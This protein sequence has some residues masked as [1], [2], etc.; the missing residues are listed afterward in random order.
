MGASGIFATSP[1]ASWQR[2][3]LRQAK[4]FLQ[5]VVE[6]VPDRIFWKDRDLRYLGCNTRFAKDAGYSR[7]D[8]LTGKTDFEMGWKDQ[9]ELYRADDKAVLESGAPRLNIE[10]PQTTPDGDTIWLRTSKVPLRD[11]DDRIIGVLGL[12]QDITA[13]KKVT[14]ELRESERRFSRPAGK[15]GTDFHDA[16]PR[17]AD[18]L[19]Q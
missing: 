10:E 13:S 15:C 17:R 11:H 12:Y 14:Q 5:L 4:D 18:Y 9:A 7:P 16:R 1:S 2:K 6:N 3:R 8:E 19:L